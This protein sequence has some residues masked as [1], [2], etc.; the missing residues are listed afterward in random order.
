[1]QRLLIVPVILF[2]AALICTPA[3]AKDENPFAPAKSGEVEG[4]VQEK[5]RKFIRVKIAE[6]GKSVR[7]TPNWSGGLPKDG[8]GL[9]KKMLK[10]IRGVKAGAR[11]KI[12]W[13][14][15]ERPRV[16]GLK[17]IVQQEERIKRD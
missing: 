9:D 3:L 16:I 1:M 10:A 4:V 6:S 12:K 8:G 17:V 5:G 7:F 11:V 15:E 2:C 13:K 14:Y